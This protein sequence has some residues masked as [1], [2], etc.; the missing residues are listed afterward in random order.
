MREYFDRI[1]NEVS[2]ALNQVNEVEFD[3]LCQSL[4]AARKIF[5]TGQGRS[6]F[7]ARA[8]AM[9]LMHLGLD[10]RFTGETTTPRIGI[11]D[12]LVAVSRSGERQ[13][14]CSHLKTAK[15]AGAGAV[16]V[17]GH[18]EATAA[19]LGSFTIVL[20][21]DEIQTQQVGGSLFE[22]AALV[23]LDAVAAALQDKLGQS[24]QDMMARHAN[25]E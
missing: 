12:L 9:R 25:L 21:P 17:T 2:Q 14:T 7:V 11:D 3:G 18:K 8:F 22:Q 23:Y 6:G 15:Q 24:N 5:V 1:L 19:S 4:L 13:V 20:D 10:S 16:V